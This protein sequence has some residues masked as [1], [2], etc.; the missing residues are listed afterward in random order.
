MSGDRKGNRSKTL[1]EWLRMMPRAQ[2]E[3]ISKA[4]A[5]ETRLIIFEAI[6]RKGEMNCSEIVSLRGLTPATVSH[7]LKVLAEAQLIECRRQGQFVYSK[8]VPGTMEEYGRSLTKIVRHPQGRKS[9]I[10]R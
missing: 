7:H 8:P 4:L 1:L 3:R 9:L 6:A 10:A 2:I 5:D